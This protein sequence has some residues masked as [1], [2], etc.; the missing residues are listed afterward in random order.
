MKHISTFCGLSF[1]LEVAD[2]S[3]CLFLAIICTKLHPMEKGRTGNILKV[4]PPLVSSFSPFIYS[5]CVFFLINSIISKLPT[6]EILVAET[7]LVLAV[8]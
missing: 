4:V 1:P 6:F 8:I 5:F 3:L 2:K 7:Y